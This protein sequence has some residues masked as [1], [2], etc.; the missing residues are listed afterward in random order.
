[1][2]DRGDALTEAVADVV[3]PARPALVLGRIMQ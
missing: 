1:V 2:N 3:E